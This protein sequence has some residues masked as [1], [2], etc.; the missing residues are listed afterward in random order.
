MAWRNQILKTSRRRVFN[1]ELLHKKKYIKIYKLSQ[2][3]GKGIESLISLNNDYWI[4]YLPKKEFSQ[5]I[6][7]YASHVKNQNYQY[8]IHYFKKLKFKK[9]VFVYSIDS[10]KSIDL[11]NMGDIEVINVENIGYDFKKYYIGL[12]KISNENFERFWLINDSFIIS[13]WNLLLKN[14]TNKSNY[15]YIGIFKSNQHKV[16]YQSFFYIINKKLLN[17]VKNEFFSCNIEVTNIDQKNELIKKYEI[18]VSNKIIKK[19]E[20]SEIFSYNKGISINHPYNPYIILGPELGIIKTKL[21]YDVRYDVFRRINIYENILLYVLNSNIFKNIY[22]FFFEKSKRKYENYIDIL[23]KEKENIKF[24][25][26]KLINF[27]VKETT[28][29][30][31]IDIS[32]LLLNYIRKYTGKEQIILDLRDIFFNFN[33]KN[34]INKNTNLKDKIRNVQYKTKNKKL[35]Y[36]CNLNSY[37]LFFDIN[38]SFIEDDVDY[39]YFSNV[40]DIGVCKNF[41]HIFVKNDCGESNFEINR[42]LKFDK[43]LFSCYDKVIYVDSNIKINNKLSNYFDKLTDDTDL[44]LFKHPERTNVDLEIKTL[45]KWKNHHKKWN[46]NEEKIRLYI[47]KE[48]L[49]SQLY[50]LSVII[51]STKKNFY[52]D[53][54]E[55]FNTYQIKRDQIYFPLFL[56]D[57]KIEKIN[58]EK[59]HSDNTLNYDGDYGVLKNWSPYFSRPFGGFHI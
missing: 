56:K 2:F 55:K 11:K 53:L 6:V 52:D 40:N 27:L 16:H 36:T 10:G 32:I 18:D 1:K 38:E 17:F 19:Y 23:K 50:W 35:V 51:S 34:N 42:K 45:N 3:T 4:K 37:D 26:K 58:L 14:Y 25:K 22:L 30:K 39:I 5:D 54:K 12:N 33:N 41:K 20:S 28:C 46:F 44:V 31:P 21:L 47:E 24:N 13:K 9:I 59:I 43:K 57:L 49:N 7:I 15:D 29:K 48:D 8:M